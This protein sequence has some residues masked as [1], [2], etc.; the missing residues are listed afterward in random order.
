MTSCT[1]TDH[2]LAA[3]IRAAVDAAL[4]ERQV[5]LARKTGTRWHIVADPAIPAYAR[6][7]FD[8]HRNVAGPI[9]VAARR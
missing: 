8:R 1:V 5:L 7:L 6:D 4:S 3:R 9:I 2:P